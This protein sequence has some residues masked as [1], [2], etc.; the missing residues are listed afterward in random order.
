VE[1]LVSPVVLILIVKPVL[2]LIPVLVV[3]VDIGSQVP[4]ALKKLQDVMSKQRPENVLPAMEINSSLLI[5]QHVLF[6]TLH[7]KLVLPLVLLVA[8]LATIKSIVQ[9]LILVLLQ[10]NAPLM[11]IRQIPASFA[12]MDI[13]LTDLEFVL[14][15]LVILAQSP[16]PP[17]ILDICK[18]LTLPIIT[19]TITTTE[20]TLPVL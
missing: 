18:K 19:T 1:T 17:R 7:A 3:L 11:T 13:S 6:V 5:N 12:I 16:A 10:F 14:H 9:Q 15:A 20:I 8:H 2:L 4:L